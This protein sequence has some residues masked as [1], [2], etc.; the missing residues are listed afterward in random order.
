MNLNPRRAKSIAGSD[1]SSYHASML[2]ADAR[3]AELMELFIGPYAERRQTRFNSVDQ[4]LIGAGETFRVRLGGAKA[5][6]SALVKRIE[7]LAPSVQAMSDSELRSRAMALRPRL[8]RARRM[9]G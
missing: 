5:R 1:N 6:Y 9:A 3:T 8:L 7:H 2:R 4:A